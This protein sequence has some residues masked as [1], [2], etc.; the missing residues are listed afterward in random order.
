VARLN[1]L[2][3]NL[4]LEWLMSLIPVS[5]YTITLYSQGK[6]TGIKAQLTSRIIYKDVIYIA[7]LSMTLKYKH[8]QIQ[9]YKS[10]PQ[11]I[12]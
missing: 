8:N 3:A 2:K 5:D 12:R 7:L 4:N 1:K 11:C 9:K 6:E 10:I